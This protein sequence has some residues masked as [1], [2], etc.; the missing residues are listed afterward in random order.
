MNVFFLTDLEGIAGVSD[1][2]YMDRS[3]E[4]YARAREL[5]SKDIDL[6]VKTAFSCGADRVYYLDGH[7]GGGNVIE[8]LIDPRAE[9]CSLVRWQELLA[10]GKIDCL[11]EL[12]SHARAG[13]IGGFLDHTVTSKEWF[14]HKVNGR[15]MSELSLHAIVCGIHGV[16]IAG[17][18]GDEV[19]CAQ[20]KEYIPEIFVGAVKH[21][22]CRNFAT[23]YE[24]CDEILVRTVREALAN[25]RSVSPYR[26]SEPVTVEL[27]Y[28]RTDMCEQALERCGADVIR[29][30]ARTLTKC[31]SHIT[32][33]N[34]LKF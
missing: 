12:G 33:Y 15:E 21:A 22:S 10:D 13:T 17:C 1:I 29:K 14:C 34:D 24:N 28:Y 2:E 4:K 19:A 26:V 11:I 16:P 3:G 5:L 7:G 9:K 27:T 18:V 30:D 6:A 20:A 25:Y 23:D 32:E 31:V 8:S